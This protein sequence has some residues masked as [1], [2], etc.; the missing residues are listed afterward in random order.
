MSSIDEC[1]HPKPNIE[2]VAILAINPEITPDGITVDQLMIISALV[3]KVHIFH[4]ENLLFALLE[5]N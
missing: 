4:I 5:L 1:P 3:C 2:V